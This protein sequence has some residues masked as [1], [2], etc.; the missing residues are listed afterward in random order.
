MLVRISS[1]SMSGSA[2]P[3]PRRRHRA[4]TVNWPPWRECRQHS[5]LRLPSDRRD[6]LPVEDGTAAAADAYVLLL[7]GGSRGA[8]LAAPVATAVAGPALGPVAALVIPV[9]LHAVAAQPLTQVVPDVAD[10]GA[11]PGR[12][13]AASAALT[14]GARAAFP[15]PGLPGPVLVRC[16]AL[17][18]RVKVLA[19]PAAGAVGRGRPTAARRSAATLGP[20]RRPVRVPAMPPAAGRTPRTAAVTVRR[21]RAGRVGTA[22]AWPVWCGNIWVT[23]ASSLVWMSQSGR[24]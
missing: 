16:A 2:S 10:A 8:R 13:A 5:A 20:P 23:H 24:G 1:P 11:E 21:A 22:P 17:P 3:I 15:A 4:T 9:A 6:P 18:R 12:R 14:P 7:P 19:D